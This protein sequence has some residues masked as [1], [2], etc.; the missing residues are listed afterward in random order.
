M[1]RIAA[2]PEGPARGSRGW[3]AV[4]FILLALPA[5]LSVPGCAEKDFSALRSG[6]EERGHYIAGV[7]FYRQEENSCGPAALASVASFWGQQVN[8]EQI[9]VKVYLPE[10]RGT[11][12]MDMER[13]LHDEGFET[14][15]FAGT[16]D[17]LK[18]R[19]RKNVP[20][21]CLLDLGFSLYRRPHY[22][23]VIGFDDANRV[24]IAHDGVTANIVIGYEKFMKAWDRAGNW[25]LVALPGTLSTEDK[26]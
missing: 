18:T 7:P 26:K 5:L 13:Y 1:P 2:L 15:S 19:I 12:P 17:G 24:I 21:I 16:L 8:A 22:I 23:T 11:L 3:S 4:T 14:T 20:V 10:L 9:K 25:M 6:I